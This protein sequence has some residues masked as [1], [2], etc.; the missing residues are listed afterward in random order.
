MIENIELSLRGIRTHKMRSFLTML[1]VI[2]GIASIIAIVSIVEGTNKKLEQSLVGSGN[3]VTSIVLCQENYPYD[4]SSGI[5]NGVPSE[6]SS[7]DLN[8][9]RAID[10][11][12]DVSVYH[13]RQNASSVYY[14][15]NTDSMVTVFGITD[16]YLNT[17]SYRIIGGR[18][19]TENEYSAGAKVALIDQDEIPALFGDEN[20]LGKVI[21]ISKEPFVVV[22]IVQKPGGTD[23]SKEY[24]SINDYYMDTANVYGTRGIYVPDGTW[25]LIFEYDEPESLAVHV[26]DTKQITRIASE[27]SEILNASISSSSV[28][29]ASSSAS[30]DAETLKTLTNSIRLML[31]AIASLSLLVGGIG[32]MNIMLVSVTE[33]TAEIG[34]KKAF[35]A[36]RRTIMAQF[37]TESAVLTSV[38]GIIGIIVGIV[39]ARIFCLVTN[40]SFAI[41]IPSIFISVGFSMF[42]GILFGAMP[43][44]KASKLNPIDAL[45]RE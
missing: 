8:A 4:F 28:K 25:P 18:D 3:N 39:L 11:V 22:G 9:V 30:E 6:I 2:I 36:K 12:S 26:T 27:A 14:Q 42:I 10:G 38:G 31:V 20:P 34:L 5:P 33:R 24:Q 45:H 16:G 35:G 13:S 17:E 23:D 37:L 41:S 40:L 32:V 7:E 43:A 15:N 21:E 29:Y 44:S 1:G 19:F